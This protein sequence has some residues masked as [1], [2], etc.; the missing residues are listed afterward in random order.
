MKHFE[1]VTIITEGIVLCMLLVHLCL[2]S[3][4]LRIPVQSSAIEEKRIA[5]TFDDGPNPLYTPVLLDGLQKRNVKATFFVLG[6]KAKENPALIRRMQEEGHLVG[7]HT[8]SHLELTSS[9]LMQFREEIAQTNELLKEL[10]KQN[11][12]FVRPPYG[13]WDK[14][15]ENDFNVMPVFWT[16]DPLDWNT[17]NVSGIV[18]CVLKQ[19][20][21]DDIILLHDC[22]PSSVEAALEIIDLL[23][24]QGYIFVTVDEIL[25]D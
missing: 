8:F 23:Q 11:P 18:D 20:K 21:S 7:N 24:K 5:I 12:L 19:A 1:I 15:L 4:S 22:Y 16:I 10:I 9:N 6:Q 3:I 2:Q 13:K 25:L 17:T 14:S